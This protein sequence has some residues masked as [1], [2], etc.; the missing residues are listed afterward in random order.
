[1]AAPRPPYEP[2]VDEEAEAPK[3]IE[4]AV[5][6][7]A[8]GLELANTRAVGSSLRRVE[9][10][11]CRLTGAELAESTWTD[12]VLEDCRLD[13]AGLRRSK[14]ERIVFRDCRM[15]ESDL[16]GA[17]LRDVVFERCTLRRASFA[18]C[19]VERVELAGCDLTGLVGVEALRG[20]RMR[21]ND[22]LENGPLFA[23]ALGIE[24]VVDE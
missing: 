1:M 10:R 13:L 11:L 4:D 17:Q 16:A 23:A 5:D 6:A 20:A 9:L 19:R 18:G 21:W 8:T 14:L 2:D 22:V 12:V 3:T 7:R 24:V 15:D